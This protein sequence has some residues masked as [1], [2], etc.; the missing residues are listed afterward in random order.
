MK[1]VLLFA[2]NNGKYDY[3][4]MA[5]YTAKRIHKFLNLPVTLVTD[6][7]T[8]NSVF[9]KIVYTNAEVDN[10]KHNTVWINKGRY[11]AFEISP[12]DETLVLDTDYLINSDTLLRPF[13]LYD[14][15]MCHKNT[16]YIMQPECDQE[17]VSNTS[18]QTLFAT[19]IYFKKTK[20]VK[21]IF[22]CLEMIQKNFNHYIN[23][24]NIEKSL[25]RNDY[26]L[27]IANRI[28]NGN[29]ECKNDVIPY[30]LLH[31][32]DFI[33]VKRLSDTEYMFIKEDKRSQYIIVRNTDFHML[34]KDNFLELINE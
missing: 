34:N 32:N 2:F 30:N 27:T 19:V 12:Y 14:D 15:F 25:Y 28:V 6:E 22:N 9:D 4:K 26:G 20:R 16:S 7:Q 24:Y 10:K 5:E 17:L 3:V 1:G 29:Y 33:K 23:V 8:N 31:V 18:F 13:E 21:H 11:K